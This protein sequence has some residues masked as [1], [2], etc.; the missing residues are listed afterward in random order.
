MMET[1]PHEVVNFIELHR[2]CDVF[3]MA[4]LSDTF[5][6]QLSSLSLDTVAVTSVSREPSYRPPMTILGMLD[7][8]LRY[9][10]VDGTESGCDVVVY[11][12]MT[13]FAGG[14]TYA[15]LMDF[16]PLVLGRQIVI[17]WP[18][19]Y[20]APETED[21]ETY[22]DQMLSVIK[23]CK[24]PITLV[25]YPQALREIVEPTSRI[26]QHPP[27]RS[28]AKFLTHDEYRLLVGAKAY[29]LQLEFSAI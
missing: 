25:G 27:R 18:Q 1:I 24:R 26:F 19:K 11:K 23:A 21:L 7:K 17:A 12:F 2:T 29:S 6:T 9:I 14:G 15:Q 20:A 16:S 8:L 28:Q 5:Y 4:N 10:E 13:P 3:R 22:A